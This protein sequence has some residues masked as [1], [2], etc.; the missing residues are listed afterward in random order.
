MMFVAGGLIW[1]NTRLQ[2]ATSYYDGF[3]HRWDHH[4]HDEAYGWPFHLTSTE[5]TLPLLPKVV[6]VLI[7]FSILAS[8]WF[9]CEWLI[10]R[11]AARK[12]V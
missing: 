7:W 10:R 8:V 3:H 9:L 6:D 1:A 11:R 5:F 4:I 12:E 2:I